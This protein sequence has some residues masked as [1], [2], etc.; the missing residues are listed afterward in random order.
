MKKTGFTLAE[1]LIT[2][3][4]IGVVASMTIPM[5]IQNAQ[6]RATVAKVKKYYTVI[7][8]AEHQWEVEN[9]CIGNVAQCITAYGAYDCRNAFGGIESKLNITARRYN[10]NPSFANIDWL[11]DESTLLNGD[12]AVI[13][14]QG[15][16]KIASNATSTCNYLFPDGATMT[17]LFPD[18]HGRSGFVFVD[19]NGKKLPNRVGK[20][21][22]PI[23]FG[24]DTGTSKSVHPHYNEDNANSY[25]GGLC[26]MRNGDGNPCADNGQSPTAYVLGH[27]E[28]PDLKSIFGK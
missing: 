3:A 1:I 12:P 16:T 6:N 18:S 27:D 19:V 22:F 13:S 21:V 15:V 2:L 28:L 17:A 8:N 25:S 10:N 4:I 5:L 26:A 20:D 9:G 24:Y 11:P 7:S 23:G 14:W